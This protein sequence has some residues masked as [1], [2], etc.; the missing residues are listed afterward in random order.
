MLGFAL[1]STYFKPNDKDLLSLFGLLFPFLYILVFLI[2]PFLY[3]RQK[4]TFLIA[5]FMLVY[6]ATQMLSYVRYSST[7][8][9]PGADFSVVTFN[10]MMGFGLVDHTQ[11][12]SEEK[13]S[14]LKKMVIS[15]KEKQVIHP[16]FK[17]G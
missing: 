11:N 1:A 9:N 6:G 13:L 17:W 15:N 4:I 16:V 12:P 8:K 7:D 10:T 14:E 2:T 3:K 5:L